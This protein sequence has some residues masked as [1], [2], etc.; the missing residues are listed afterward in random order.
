MKNDDFIRAVGEI[1]GEYIDEAAPRVKKHGIK[2]QKFVAVAA[3]IAVLVTGLSL[4]LFLPFRMI[5]LDPEQYKGS[6]Y[7]SL[8]VKL[9]P[10]Y[11]DE[12]EYDNNFD[13]FFGD[14]TL[15]GMVDAD[16]AAGADQMP[17]YGLETN[18]S[19]SNGESSSQYEEVTDNQVEGV[20]EAD[21]I[22]R[23]STHIFYLNSSGILCAY[24][25]E[26]EASRMVGSCELK[27]P[28][29]SYCY[30]GNYGMYLSEDC[31]TATVVAPFSDSFYGASIAIFS[32]DVS[33]PEAMKIKSRTTLLGSYVS[34]R[35]VDG[36]LLLISN[37]RPSKPDF[38][39][40]E[41]FVP[42]IDTGCGLKLIP[43]DNIVCPDVPTSL[44]YTVITMLDPDATEPTESMAL[45]SYSDEVY[46]S[47]DSV[48]ATRTDSKS[49]SCEG[50][51]ISKTVTD[52][53]R[54]AYG[55]SGLS[56][57]GSITVD[58]YV[59]NQYSLDQN[60]NVL[61][62]VTTTRQ[63]VC[64][65]DGYYASADTTVRS[66]TNASL[67]CI[68]TDS[69]EIISSVE[70]FAPW[71]E[72]VRSVR[73]DGDSAYV[74]TSVQLTD[75]VF[76]FDLSD[77][78]NITYKDTG[79]IDGYSSSL[80]N[81]GGGYLLGIGY[82]SSTSTLKVEVYEEGESGVISVCKFEREMTSFSTD[83]KSY[84]IN[85]EP[86]LIGIGI[87]NM[88]S[89]GDNSRYILL[90]FDGYQL[91]LLLDEALKGDNERKRSVCIDS[92]LYLLGDE[93]KAVKIG[94]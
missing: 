65:T 16:F 11:A 54:I 34:S 88:W 24:S 61:R 39:N 22:K 52:I 82:G 49:E 57:L 87:T 83:Y 50:Y 92:Y 5:T 19:T 17:E 10:L 59:N 90:H 73:F 46:V 29:S 63:S 4:W 9:A 72:V 36:K 84:Y 6:D 3:C 76:F 8:I 15:G 56:L 30:Y 13:K 74:C 81:L 75:P 68:S 53:S 26:K 80:V 27:I 20:I 33:S 18:G 55:E 47:R 44:K 67:Y 51:G 69:L 85:R 7:Y 32:L 89:S 60:E 40:P 35:M 21:A 31:K 93:F 41:T 14:I 94:E 45:V 43:A 58:G 91:H 28:D 12:P 2:W 38:E 48:Y 78:N 70:A 71:G 23:S 79:T 64:Y 42:Q 86:S 62:V 66:G 25:I 37:Y 1:N 77:I